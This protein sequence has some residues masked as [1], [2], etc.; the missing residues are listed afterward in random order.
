MFLGTVYDEHSDRYSFAT[1]SVSIFAVTYLSTSSSPQARVSS[2][3]LPRRNFPL[4]ATHEFS[5]QKT[6][7]YLKFVRLS[8]CICAV[9]NI[10]LFDRALCPVSSGFYEI[11]LAIAR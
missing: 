5:S 2:G 7:S 3:S 9:H 6:Q 4:E 10:H 8:K 11:G 1:L